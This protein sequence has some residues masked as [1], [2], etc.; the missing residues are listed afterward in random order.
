M[1]GRVLVSKIGLD[2]HD[3]GAKVVARALKE[4]GFE[5]IYTGLHKTP[6]EV[7]DI[8]LEEDVDLIGVSILSGAHN[9]LIPKLIEE[10]K[11]RKIEDKPIVV[12]GII[13][14]EDFEVLKSW[15]VK[16]IFIP[17]TPLKEIIETVEKLV[18]EYRKNK[19]L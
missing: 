14:D 16:A 4:A 12:G 10:L 6:K 9:T 15:G 17:G 7:A 2:G 13:P 19:E 3:R 11:E 18:K 1:K 8:A 5:V